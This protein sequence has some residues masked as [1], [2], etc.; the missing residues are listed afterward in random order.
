MALGFTTTAE[1]VAPKRFSLLELFF[2]EACFEYRFERTQCFPSV[3]ALGPSLE[4]GTLAGTQ[5]HQTRNASR[6]NLLCAIGQRHSSTE[7]PQ[8]LRQG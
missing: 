5:H 4:F 6:V 2:S 8:R 3:A 1:V 7:L